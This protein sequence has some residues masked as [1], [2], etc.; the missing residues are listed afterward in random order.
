M[1]F[2]I[3]TLI[4][5]VLWVSIFTKTYSLVR[6]HMGFY[7]Y[8]SIYPL[9]LIL[10]FS[11][12]R[13]VISI[14]LPFTTVINSTTV[15]PLIQSIL[16]SS[17]LTIGTT[18]INLVKIITLIWLSGFIY[19]LIKHIHDYIRFKHILSFLPAT[20][21]SDLINVMEKSKISKSFL[22]NKII[23]HE[24]VESPAIIGFVKP[25]TLM[26]NISFNT[27]ELECIILHEYTHYRYGH[28]YIKCFAELIRIIFWWNPMFKKLSLEVS[29]ILEMHSDMVVCKNINSQQQKD[30]LNGIVK[31]LS[32]IKCLSNTTVFSCCLIEDDNAEKLKQRFQMI[33]GNNYNRKS[34]HDYTLVPCILLCFL[35][36]YALVVQPY[37]EPTNDN[38]GAKEAINTQCYLLETKLGYELY[39]SNDTF[40]AE[41]TYIDDSLKDLK[42]INIQK[43]IK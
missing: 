1:H 33:L 32:N 31:V 21:Y 38:F 11:V 34:K 10:T 25:I 17:F 19:L 3:F 4:I 13:L 14:E 15:L 24:S 20:N 28:I 42:I 39:D 41:V 18:H 27:E 2:T 37:S 5:A 29:H 43:E 9:L 36:S 26:P 30:Y 35:L 12:L 23:V 22:N 8:F 7:K 16:C 6:R 40:I